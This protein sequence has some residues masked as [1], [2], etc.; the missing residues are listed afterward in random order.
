MQLRLYSA[1]KLPNVNS[2]TGV[3]NR[4]SSPFAPMKTLKPVKPFT[5]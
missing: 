2:H 5:L 3:K 4:A 1:G